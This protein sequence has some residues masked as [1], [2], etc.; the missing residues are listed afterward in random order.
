[1]ETEPKLAPPGAGLPFVI[2]M[3]ARFFTGPVIAARSNWQENAR[4]FDRLNQKIL[5]EV[6]AVPGAL[7]EKKILVPPQ[8]GLEDS[9]R[10]WSISMTLEHLWTVNEAMKWFMVE[11]GAGRVPEGEANPAAVKPKGAIP[12]EK[13]VNDFRNQVT[14]LMAQLETEVKDKKSRARFRHPWFGL[15]KVIQWQWVLQAHARVHLQQIRAI[16][17]GLGV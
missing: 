15:M 9:S 6:D 16:R 7:L 2:A 3:I 4:S 13:M 5:S 8:L 10:Y 1:M 12:A 11:L 14:T 17:K